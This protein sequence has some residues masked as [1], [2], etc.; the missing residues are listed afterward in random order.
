MEPY[1]FSTRHHLE[2]GVGGC[3]KKRPF[4]ATSEGGLELGV[5]IKVEFFACNAVWR[6]ILT[7]NKNSEES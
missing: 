5:P 3:F 2:N 6:R 1:L 7:S 4:I